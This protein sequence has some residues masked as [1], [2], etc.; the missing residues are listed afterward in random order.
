M[1]LNEQMIPIAADEELA[2]KQDDL[3]S[4]V[5]PAL[6]R[7]HAH[8]ASGGKEGRMA[9]FA[10]APAPRARRLLCPGPHGRLSLCP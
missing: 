7:P 1:D 4:R 5:S 9:R 6:A 10:R 2:I 3:Q 8:I